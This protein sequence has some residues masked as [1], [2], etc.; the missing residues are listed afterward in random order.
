MTRKLG[1]LRLKELAQ[2]LRMILLD[3]D[4]VFTDGGI[5][6]VGEDAE[7]K[8]FDAQDGMGIKLARAVGI[9]VGIISARTSSVVERRAKELGI[10]DVYQ[11]AERKTDI[12][13]I[14]LKKHKIVASQAS[15]IG[16]DVQDIPIMERVGIPIAVN[17]A[18]NPVK[19]C[20]VYVTRAHGGYGAIREAVEWLL[21]LRGEREKAYKVFTD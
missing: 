4:G 5:I 3:V 16:D 6:L 17:N 11:S 15:F 1:D 13:D 8:R 14:L 21:E 12:L 20:S 19:D 2:N 10:D 18:R 9:R 7:A